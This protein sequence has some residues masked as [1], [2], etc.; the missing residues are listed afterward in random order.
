MLWAGVWLSCLFFYCPSI[1]VVHI[2]TICWKFF[3]SQIYYFQSTYTGF[4]SQIL[5]FFTQICCRLILGESKG[6][7]FLKLT[8]S[9]PVDFS[10]N[11]TNHRAQN[12]PVYA[13]STAIGQSMNTTP[14]Q[15]SKVY[16]KTQIFFVGAVSSLQ[17]FKEIVFL[18]ELVS[19][20][21][22]FYWFVAPA[23][24]IKQAGELSVNMEEAVG[25]SAN[26]R[27]RK[28]TPL[29]KW[30]KQGDTMTF[31]VPGCILNDHGKNLN[32]NL[33]TLQ[34][35]LCFFSFI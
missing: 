7:G 34:F 5:D 33:S 26:G 16:L 4:K 23:A 20:L 27:S 18:V 30:A 6:C 22:L 3:S 29:V 19:P 17:E 14:G 24:L 2:S 35:L 13:W 25:P 10:G 31:L 1:A 15:G 21:L 8:S 9:T 32:G 11:L 28:W 12:T